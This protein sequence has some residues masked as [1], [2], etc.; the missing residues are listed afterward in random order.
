[1]RHLYKNFKKRFHGKVFEKKLWLA[2]RAYRKDIFEKHYNIMKASSPKQI[3]WIEENHKQ[4][5]ARCYFSTGN[6]CDYVTNEI[7]KTF[8]NWIKHEK[9]LPVIELMDRVRQKIMET[10]FQRSLA[11]KLN[12]KVL[13]HIVKHLNAKLEGWLVM[14]STKVLDTWQRLLVFIRT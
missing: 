12:T 3:E 2:S 1:M 11:K 14:Q 4:L 13:P 8:N 7:A 9:L 5:R 6:K 10:L